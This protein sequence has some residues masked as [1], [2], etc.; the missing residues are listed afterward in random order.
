MKFNHILYLSLLIIFLLSMNFIA[1]QEVNETDLS[2]N[3]LEIECVES[4]LSSNDLNIESDNLNLG[5]IDDSNELSADDW[6]HI[7][8]SPNGT[9]NGSSESCPADFK[10]TLSNIG[11]NTVVHMID[12]YYTWK[13]SGASDYI[14]I[15]NKN[16]IIV[17]A[18][19]PGKVFLNSTYSTKATSQKPEYDLNTVTNITFTNIIFHSSPHAK[20]VLQF[21]SSNNILLENCQFVNYIKT[22]KKYKNILILGNT[23]SNVS[24]INCSFI[25]SSTSAS[26]ILVDTCLFKN[27]TFENCTSAN[28]L[29]APTGNIGAY[30]CIFINNRI[31]IPSTHYILHI[32]GIV[33]IFRIFIF[34]IYNPPKHT[35]FFISTYIFWSFF[36]ITSNT[37]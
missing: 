30:G 31:F 2:E 7:Y 34:N 14:K 29:M 5:E 17:V 26:L 3:N 35:N 11:D 32:R 12:G 16:N 6:N 28:A 36:V 27:C 21:Q 13:S 10:Q 1:A 19:H 18:D 4:N 22:T 20:S 8:V 33:S 37:K 15:T 24:I 25:N 9:G 23:N